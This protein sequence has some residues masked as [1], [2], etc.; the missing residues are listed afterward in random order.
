MKA[1]ARPGLF[2]LP[3]CMELPNKTKL[4]DECSNR[5][6]QNKIYATCLASKD[7]SRETQLLGIV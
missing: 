6:Q 5:G 2:S 7:L 3:L 4:S 1:W